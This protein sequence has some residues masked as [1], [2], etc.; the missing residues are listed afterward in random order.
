MSRSAL[1]SLALALLN[2]SGLAGNLVSTE[3]RDPK[4]VFDFF[5]ANPQHIG[6]GLN[7]IRSYMNPLMEEP[8]NLAPD[9]MDII[10]VV[11]GTELVTLARHNY[12]K[13]QEAVERMRY[14]ASL[15]VKFKACRQ[16]AN[17]YGYSTAD[18]YDFVDVVP[19]AMAEVAHWQQLGYGLVIPQI[20]EKTFTIDEIR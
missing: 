14:Y 16:A 7:W 3:Y 13:Y 2:T 19:S 4:V 8:Y 15:G 10:V 20:H 5:F 6:S 1:L 17:D 12:D 9:F 11:H 18:F